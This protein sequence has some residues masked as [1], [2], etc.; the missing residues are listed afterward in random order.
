[1]FLSS[2]CKFAA[3]HIYTAKSIKSKVKV[4]IVRLALAGVNFLLVFGTG[5]CFGFVLNTGVITQT[6]FC[7]CWAGLATR[8]AQDP[9]P[10]LVFV[11]PHWQG[12]WGCIGHWKNTQPGQVTEMAQRDTP[13]HMTSWSVL[14]V[15]GGRKKVESL[16]RW[17]LLSEVT[18]RCDKALL[19]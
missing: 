11:L 8:Q 2:F 9:R 13:D 17:C 19:S 12:T 14:K 7:C 16:K 18:V 10:F 4:C 6:C 1:M 5:P 15:G 3:W